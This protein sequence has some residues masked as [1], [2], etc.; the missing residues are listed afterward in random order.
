M[1][2]PMYFQVSAHASLTKAGAHL[3]PSVMGNAIA[4]LLT[5][6]IIKR[7]L[8]FSLDAFLYLST[9]INP[10]PVDTSF[11]PSSAPSPASHAILSLSSAGTDTRPFLNPYTSSPAALAT[12]S[13]SQRRSSRSR[14]VW[15]QIR[16]LLQARACS[17]QVMLVWL[18]GSASLLRYCRA[19]WGSSC[20]FRWRGW[21]EGM[22]YELRLWRN[23]CQCWLS[24]FR[25][26]RKPWAILDMYEICK[27]RLAC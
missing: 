20:G 1:L 12:A 11:S 22:R 25:L 2:V 5:G 10:A 15:T 4:G 19:H 3:V 16:W 23:E 6:F 14:L 17:W 7:Y 21:M 8:W 24:D 27:G 18:V 26:S 13:L 9:N